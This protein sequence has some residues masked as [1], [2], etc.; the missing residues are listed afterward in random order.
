MEKLNYN[1]GFARKCDVATL[2]KIWHE[3]FGDGES[4]IDFFFSSPAFSL[5]NSVVVFE[6]GSPVSVLYLLESD[7]YINGEP[8][9]SYYVYAV[10]TLKACRNR[11]YMRAALDFAAKTAQSRNAEYL[12]LVPESEG[13]F[14]M[15]EKCGY[16]NGISYSRVYSKSTDL[17]KAKATLSPDSFTYEKYRRLKRNEIKNHNAVILR[18]NAFDYIFGSLKKDGTFLYSLSPECFCFYEKGDSGVTVT[19]ICPSDKESASLISSA[20]GGDIVLRLP[21][22]SGGERYSFGMYFTLKGSADF[23]DVYFG[24]PY[25]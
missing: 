15:Y 19:D 1:V 16:K 3:A 11:G 18:E 4:E 12:F 9:F 17:P 22:E 5:E 8:H 13:L 7:I 6:N 25:G 14:N 24:H 10:A 20:L 21:P 2:K 23:N